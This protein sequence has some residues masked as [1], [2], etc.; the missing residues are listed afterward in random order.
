VET[1]RDPVQVAQRAFRQPPFALMP[2]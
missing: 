1:Q 2:A